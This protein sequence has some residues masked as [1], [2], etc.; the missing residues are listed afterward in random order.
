M[1]ARRRQKNSRFVRAGRNNG[2]REL[3]GKDSEEYQSEKDDD[4]AET[5]DE[6]LAEGDGTRIVGQ[7]PAYKKARLAETGGKRSRDKS[8]GDSEEGSRK[9]FKP[10]TQVK[11]GDAPAS[12]SKLVRKADYWLAKLLFR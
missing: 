3:E 5:E 8:S 12:T 9:K 6:P 11:S 7:N 2:Q 1:T 4:G 10:S